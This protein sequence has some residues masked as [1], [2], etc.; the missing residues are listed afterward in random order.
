MAE[1]S[2]GLIVFFGTESE[3]RNY[4]HGR[5]ID[6]RRVLL[7]AAVVNRGGLRGY[8]GPVETILCSAAGVDNKGYFALMDEINQMNVLYGKQEQ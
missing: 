2:T 5:K 3:R 7:A 8:A 4:V 6:P 1:G